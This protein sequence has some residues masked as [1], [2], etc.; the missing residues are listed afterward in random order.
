MAKKNPA[1]STPLQ[2][3]ML[4]KKRDERASHPIQTTPPTRTAP[5]SPGSMTTPNLSEKGSVP[6]RAHERP[7]PQ[8]KRISDPSYQ[9]T[10]QP[11][12]RFKGE[13][14]GGTVATQM[15]EA[16][17]QQPEVRQ[18]RQ[19]LQQQRIQDR[20][21]AVDAGAIAERQERG[22]ANAFLAGAQIEHRR[23]AQGRPTQQEAG[24]LKTFSP[25]PRPGQRKHP[26]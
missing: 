5:T 23:D 15:T 11:P 7:L 24:R 18:K 6:V 25:N 8:P 9:E 17:I 16:A 22:A 26:A 21:H 12:S 14:A 4:A 20:Q 13:K 19:T 2:H 3:R 1:I 10:R